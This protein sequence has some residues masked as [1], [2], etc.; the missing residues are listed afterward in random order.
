MLLKRLSIITFLI[1]LFSFSLVGCSSTKYN[2]A[3][4]LYDSGEYAQAAELFSELGEYENSIDMLNSCEDEIGMQEHSDYNFLSDLEEC[5]RTRVEME[6]ADEDILRI[7]NKEFRQIN[8]YVSLT[9]YDRDLKNYALQ[10]IEGLELQR[11][12]LRHAQSNSQLLWHEGLTTS[13]SAL[14]KINKYFPFFV[15]DQEFITTYLSRNET[16]NKLYHIYMDLDIALAIQTRIA[17]E[18]TIIDDETMCIPFVNET[19][20]TYELIFYFDFYDIDNNLVESTAEHFECILPNQDYVLY[21]Y[22][23]GIESWENCS[24]RWDVLLIQSSDSPLDEI[25]TF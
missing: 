12:A 2:K 25:Q 10:Y 16:S 18:L 15:N 4:R 22:H 8:N 17:S 14:E 5:I 19:E 21:F 3:L 24:V 9:F 7:V 1:I 6:E 11:L 20:Y 13:Y 23:P